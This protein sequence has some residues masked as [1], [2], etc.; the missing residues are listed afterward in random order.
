MGF[1]LTITEI[2]EDISFG[3]DHKLYGYVGYGDIKESFSE[4][5]P[6]IRKQWTDDHDAIE[7]FSDG[8][9]YEVYFCESGS[10]EPIELDSVIFS[11]WAKRY[12]DEFRRLRGRNNK[13]ESYIEHLINSPCKKKLEW[14]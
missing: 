5:I 2:E 12:R 7:D 6:E 10:T 14:Y 1:R 8:D 11:I 3:G 4:L 13:F 9:I